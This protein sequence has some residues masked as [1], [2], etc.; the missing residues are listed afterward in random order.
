MGH[1]MGGAGT[2][3]LGV[4]PQDLPVIIVQ[5]DADKAV[6][7]ARTGRENQNTEYDSPICR[8]S[9]RHSCRRA[10]DRG[11]YKKSGVSHQTFYAKPSSQYPTKPTGCPVPEG[12][13]APL[14]AADHPGVR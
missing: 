8:N 13:L 9:G 5:G 4:N 1:S 11:L 10:V 3:Y 12:L 7:V 2:I 14:R 6:P